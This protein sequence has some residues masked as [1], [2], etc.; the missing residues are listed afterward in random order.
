M[1]ITNSILTATY[2]GAINNFKDL[3]K[4]P[5]ETSS[6]HVAR[7]WYMSFERQVNKHGNKLSVIDSNGDSHICS[8]EREERKLPTSSGE[9]Y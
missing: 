9:D 3:A 8:L 4:D 1:K 2:E 5:F 6:Q 7:C